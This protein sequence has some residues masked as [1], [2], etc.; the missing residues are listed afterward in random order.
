MALAIR[1]GLTQRRPVAEGK[2]VTKKAAPMVLSGA[3]RVNGVYNRKITRDR[4]WALER[5]VTLAQRP[6][7]LESTPD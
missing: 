3:A 4:E 2:T 7:L 6:I 5:C 1:I